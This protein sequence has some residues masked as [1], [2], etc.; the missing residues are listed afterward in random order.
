MI[1]DNLTRI[2]QTMAA[3]AQRVGRDPNGIKLVAVTKQVDVGQIKQAVACGQLLFGESYLQEAAGKISQIASPAHWH[4]IGHL[5]SNKARSAVALFDMIETVDSF[6]LARLLDKHAQTLRRNLSILIQVNTGD[7]THK[8]GVAPA[9]TETL[10]R[11]IVMETSLMLTGLMTIPPFFSEPEQSR[12]YFRTLA[13]IAADLARKGLFADN[14]NVELSMGMS[15]DFPIAIEEGA[16]I[17]RVGTAL[18]GAR[19]IQGVKI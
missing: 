7:E 2:R 6:K 9:E 10:A 14:A 19:T 3:A 17:V 4:F 18:F 13:T 8:S 1:K 11:R 12:P 15:A 16:T 5:Q